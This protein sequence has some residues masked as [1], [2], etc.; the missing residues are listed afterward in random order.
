MN[1]KITKDVNVLN[2]SH[3]LELFSLMVHLQLF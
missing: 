1:N 2:V 3:I